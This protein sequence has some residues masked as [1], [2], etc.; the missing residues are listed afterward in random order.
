[1]KLTKF[2]RDSLILIRDTP[3]ITALGFAKSMWPKSH[4]HKNKTH[5]SA[6]LCAGSYLGKLRKKGWVEIIDIFIYN[7]Y[8]LTEAGKEA[9]KT[10]SIWTKK[11]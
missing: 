5:K 6:Y 9:L 8:Q 2:Q 11:K 10:K 1:M 3:G 4:M 7:T